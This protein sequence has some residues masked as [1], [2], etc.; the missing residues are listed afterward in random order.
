VKEIPMLNQTTA[1]TIV[2]QPTPPAPLTAYDEDAPAGLFTQPVN[3]ELLEQ[4]EVDELGRRSRWLPA[5]VL[6]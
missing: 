6:I 1:T 3:V 2:A 4:L 5:D